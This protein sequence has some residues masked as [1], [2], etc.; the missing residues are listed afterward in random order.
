MDRNSTW[1]ALSGVLIGV[2]ALTAAWAAGPGPTER[3]SP[4]EGESRA[5]PAAVAAERLSEPEDAVPVL[6]SG[7]PEDPG[8]FLVAL[9]VAEPAPGERLYLCD[10]AGCPL[11]EILPDREG[12]ATLGPLAPGRYRITWGQTEIA[13][14]RLLVNAALESAEGRLWTDGEL[15]HLE[16]GAT[17]TVRLWVRLPRPGYYGLRLCDRYGRSWSRDLYLPEDAVPG[18]DGSFL[19]TVDFPGLS[20]G[21][22]TACRGRTVLAQLELRA[23]ETAEAEIRLEETIQN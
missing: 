23:G 20:P 5:V 21:F 11:E 12:D 3:G 7:E 18:P 9:R 14:F 17:G 15:L 1:L 19:R 2:L 16:R 22:Y 4:A 13:A 6:A 8:P 10:E